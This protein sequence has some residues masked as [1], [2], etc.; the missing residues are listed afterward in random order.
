[1]SGAE[2]RRPVR[3]SGGGGAQLGGDEGDQYKNKVF[4]HP[5]PLT[6]L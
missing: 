2:F 5:A 4:T 1:M 6:N 3:W